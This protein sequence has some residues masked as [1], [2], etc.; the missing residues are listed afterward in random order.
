[1]LEGPVLPPRDAGGRD[2]GFNPP[3]ASRA[4]GENE[5]SCSL[6]MSRQSNKNNLSGG[7]KVSPQEFPDQFSFDLDKSGQSNLIWATKVA[8]CYPMCSRH[9]SPDNKYPMFFCGI[10]SL[11]N[12]FA[13]KGQWV[14]GCSTDSSLSSIWV[15][16]E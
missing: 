16:C 10:F 8:K 3:P 5:K 9:V 2:A 4:L 13:S 11:D 1:M 15:Q 14:H 6:T 7:P 12:Y